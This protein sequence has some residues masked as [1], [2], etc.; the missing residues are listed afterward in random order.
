LVRL[1]EN[2]GH[3]RLS[4][5]AK[6]IGNE[7]PAWSSAV[8]RT[9]AAEWIEV[10]GDGPA[11]HPEFLETMEPLAPNV[12]Q[13]RAD[14]LA[15]LRQAQEEFQTMIADTPGRPVGFPQAGSSGLASPTM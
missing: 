8:A 7:I 5:L 9:F 15:R 1:V 10:A 6:R 13:A 14:H 2:G 11:A 3:S 4:W 12:A